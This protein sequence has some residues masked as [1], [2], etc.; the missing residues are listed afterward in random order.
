MSFLKKL[1]A[2]KPQAKLEG[3]FMTMLGKSKFGKTTWAVE[4]VEE[5]FGSL[6]NALLLATEIG[7][8]TM[9]GV[10]AI[11]ITGF[12]W[13]ENEDED[14]ED[15]KAQ[16]DDNEERGFIEVVDELIENKNE[17][18][19]KFIIID[20]ITALE[21]YATAHVIRQANRQDN[22]AKRYKTISNIP[23]GDGYTMVGEAIYEQIDRLKK[24][25]FGV[26]VIGHEKTR[27]IKNKDGYEYDYT[28]L[29]V[30][31]KVS[32]IIERESDFIIYADLMTTEGEDGK[33]KEERMLR[34]RSD[35]NFL[36]GCRFKHF[37]ASTSNEPADFLKAFKEAVEASSGKK[38]PKKVV[39]V[40]E[41]VE[42]EKEHVVE[43]KPKK[44]STKK[45]KAKEVEPDVA[46][47]QVKAEA[48]AEKSAV[49]STTDEDVAEAIEA[50][51]AEIGE[52]L[53]DMP[54]AD[55]KKCAVEFKNVTGAIDYKQSNSLED[56]Q[57]VLEFVKELA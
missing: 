21:R 50:V 46:E 37:P 6:D 52:L 43:E 16:K 23:W 24:A 22:P 25:G 33:P 34:Y 41:E 28:G 13:A 14:D 29:N 38:L 15:V 27:K 5:H 39:E 47:E 30:M 57:E 1:K 31:G 55:K 32:D 11:P 12:E 35:G 56:L 18:D 40:K 36:A 45:Q 48:E 3:Y 10:I 54:L 49:E 42:D 9:D 17:V 8:K 7:Y 4:V 53:A 51:K 19:F 26:L 44:T 20:T 2:N